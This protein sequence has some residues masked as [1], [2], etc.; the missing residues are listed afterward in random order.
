MAVS[1]TKVKPVLKNDL[2]LGWIIKF[3]PTDIDKNFGLLPNVL[4]LPYDKSGWFE[5]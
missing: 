1:G 5:S 3:Y 2:I 4:W